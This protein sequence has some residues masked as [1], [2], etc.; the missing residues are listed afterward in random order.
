LMWRMTKSRGQKTDLQEVQA[1]LLNDM[2]VILTKQDDRYVLKIHNM[3]FP[4][5]S[6]RM[7]A[8]PIIKLNNLHHRPVATGKC[9]II[10]K[11]FRE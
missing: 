8:K 9:C 4:G 2:I 6:D 5:K 3:G 7:M 1:V 11:S 10:I